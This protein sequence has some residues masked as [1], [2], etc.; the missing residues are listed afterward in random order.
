MSLLGRLWARR[1]ERPVLVLLAAVVLVSLLSYPFV[2]WWLRAN[3]EFASDFRFGDFGAYNAAIERWHEGES[4]YRR[5]EEGGFWGTYLYPPVVLL[6]FWP[7]TA[8]L[9]FR[10]AAMAWVLTTALFLWVGLQALVAAQGYD[11]RWFER[12]GLAWLVAG[13]Q[14]VILTAK[15]GQTALFMGGLLSFAGA[16]LIRDGRRS[17]DRTDDS[18]SRRRGRSPA[19]PRRGSSAWSSSR[20]RRSAHICCTTGGGW[21]GRSSRW[22]PSRGCRSG[23]STSPPTGRT[24]KCSAGGRTG[25]RRRAVADALAPAV[26][27]T[28]RV[29]ARRASGPRARLPGRRRSLRARAAARPPERLRDGCRGRPAF[30]PQTYAY[31]FVALLPVAVVLLA[32]ELERDGSRNSCWSA[33]CSSTCTL[34]A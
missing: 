34:T 11:L 27:Q 13:F 18:S 12:L 9:E 7:F 23:S 21:P 26:L 32:V 5:T 14:P 22:Y 31:Y 4:L 8:L 29:A 20:T 28:A 15:L 25:E 6:L 10:P 19:A 33:S 1:R 2:D 3:F 30:H 17:A 16:A 24:S